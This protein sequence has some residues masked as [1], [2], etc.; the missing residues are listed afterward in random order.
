ME[1][2]LELALTK[3]ARKNFPNVP[4]L[5]VR[6]SDSLDFHDIFVGSIED[7]LLEAYQLGF[8]H[9]KKE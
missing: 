6:N 9:G 2:E 1:K 8:E 4:T 5:K 7:A 3:I